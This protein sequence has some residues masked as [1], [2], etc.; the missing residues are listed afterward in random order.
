MAVAIRLQHKPIAALL[1][2]NLNFSEAALDVWDWERGE[3]AEAI[4]HSVLQV[5]GVGVAVSREL[6]G[7]GVVSGYEVGS[8]TGDGEDG[9]G[10]SEFVHQL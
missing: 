2:R 4:R 10:D 6:A 8:W 3:E 7:E 1:T 5:C 9:F